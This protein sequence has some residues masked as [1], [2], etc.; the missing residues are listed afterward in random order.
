M[1]ISIREMVLVMEDNYFISFKTQKNNVELEDLIS[2]VLENVSTF[3]E[4]Y[5]PQYEINSFLKFP[6]RWRRIKAIPTESQKPFY[7]R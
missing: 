2:A 3:E 1:K 4:Q 6:R 7:K 5:I